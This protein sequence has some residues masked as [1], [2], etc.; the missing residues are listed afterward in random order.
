MK[1]ASRPPI[2]P[3]VRP[4]STTAPHRNIEHILT[5]IFRSL[6]V[7]SLAINHDGYLIRMPFISGPRASP[8]QVICESLAELQELLA[9]CLAGKNNAA[10]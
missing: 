4:P 2:E 8:A 5:L 9:N 6:Q 10:L 7:I 1:L 3:L